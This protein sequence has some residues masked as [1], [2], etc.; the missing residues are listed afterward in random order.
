MHIA[1]IKL[2]NLRRFE[3]V[4][5]DL[6]RPDGRL[7]GWT[8]FVGGNSSGKSTLLKGIALALVGPDAGRTLMG[9]PA[10]WIRRGSKRAEA[11]VQLRWDSAHD[12]FTKGGK[13]PGAKF[14]AAVRWNVDR[15]DAFPHFAAIE[16][17][18]ASGTRIQSADR[19]PWEPNARGWFAAAY[20]PMRRFTGSSMTAMRSAMEPVASR[21]VTLFRED[22]A[23]SESEEWLKKANARA[24]EP[25]REDQ[26][27]V[28]EGVKGLINDG[29]LPQGMRIGRITIDQVFVEDASGLELPMQDVSDGCRS[30]IATVLDIAHGM[31]EVYGSEGLWERRPDGRVVFGRPGVIL[32]DE[33]EAHLHPQWQREIPRWFTEHFPQVQFL[34]TTHSPLI[35]QA[36]DENGIIVLPLQDEPGRAPRTLSTEEANRIRMGRAEKTLLGAAFGLSTTRSTWAVSQMDRWKR[37]ESKR[38][39]GARLTPAEAADRERLYAALQLELVL[40]ADEQD[41]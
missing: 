23:L 36:A 32:I 25:G 38:R 40:P 35:A 17:R 10:G 37:L 28:L 33:V 26:W 39:A 6:M 7:A 29:L 22:A 11:G 20:G 13:N 1:S 19:G 21:F 2:E 8:V 12:A 14:E 27:N 3:S 24:N 16:R 15:E 34:V 9:S 30:I 18:N 41:T 5:I 4:E 31:A